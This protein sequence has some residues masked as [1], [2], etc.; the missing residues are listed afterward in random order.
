MKVGILALQGSF[1]EHAQILQK[2]KVDFIYVRTKED[3]QDLTHFIIPGGE[4]TTLRKLLEAYR[5]WSVLESRIMNR[6]LRV[7]GTCAGAILCQYLGLDVEICRNGFGAQQSS[8]IDSLDSEQFP[9]LQGVFIRAPRFLSV[10]KGVKVLATF[11]KEPVLVEQGSFLA[12]SFHP[13]LCD[14][15]RIHEY[16]FNSGLQQRA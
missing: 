7:F 10:G 8:F 15:M 1:V 9:E 3:L 2:L 6:E 12:L 11:Q 13:E 14:E 16:F 5:M 4:S